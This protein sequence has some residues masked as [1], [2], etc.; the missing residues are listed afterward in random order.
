[1]KYVHY[2]KPL[3]IA[4]TAQLYEDCRLLAMNEKVSMAEIIRAI[5][6]RQFTKQNKGDYNE[7]V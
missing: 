4:L 1:M 2:T 6:T 7:K 5:L 3:T